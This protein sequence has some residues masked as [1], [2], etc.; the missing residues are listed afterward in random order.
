MNADDGGNCTLSFAVLRSHS[1][2]YE[3]PAMRSSARTPESCALKREGGELAALEVEEEGRHRRAGVALLL[4]CAAG[5]AG[6]EAWGLALMTSSATAA[7]RP[8][9][10]HWTLVGRNPFA[11]PRW[12]ELPRFAQPCVKTPCLTSP[13]RP[14][15]PYP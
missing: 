6:G 3:Q 15:H 10:H 1:N 13:C 8:A 4:G 5:A 9:V 7:L 11:W 2:D 14:V 12:D